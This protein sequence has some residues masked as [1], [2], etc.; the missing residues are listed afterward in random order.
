MRSDLATSCQFQKYFR[1][2]K[3]HNGGRTMLILTFKRGE[4]AIVGDDV[5]VVYLGRDGGQIR[6]GFAAPKEIRIDRE[7]VRRRI[8]AEKAQ[9]IAV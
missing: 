1:G 8:E 3:S 2:S 5:K 7:C 9:A 4:A 6:L